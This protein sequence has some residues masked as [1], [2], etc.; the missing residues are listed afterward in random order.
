MATV[1]TLVIIAVAGASSR[2][3]H[4]WSVTRGRASDMTTTAQ[5][6]GA[7]HNPGKAPDMTTTAV[8]PG[9][10]HRR[11]AARWL[12]L[13]AAAI[14]ALLMLSPFFIM[15]LNALKSPQDYSNNGPLSFPTELYTDG[16][17]AFWT[18]TDFPSSS[19][20]RC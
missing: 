4:A 13:A 14:F 15:A 16:L 10:R 3:R 19:S 7:R 11:G 5:R 1:L 17:V 12:V 2:C 6:P 9:A 18:R 20:T 8:K